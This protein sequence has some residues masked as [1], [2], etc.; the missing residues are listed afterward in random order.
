MNMKSAMTANM[1]SWAMTAPLPVDE[2]DG[3][4]VVIGCGWYGACRGAVR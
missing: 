3:A 1:P 4:M 2:D